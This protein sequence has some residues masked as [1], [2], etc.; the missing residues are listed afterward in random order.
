MADI[1]IFGDD[2]VVPE[3][4]KEAE[5][6]EIVE[7]PETEEKKNE[8]ESEKEDENKEMEHENGTEDKMVEDGG[9]IGEFYLLQNES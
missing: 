9:V 1:D 8:V 7:K 3:E 4:K 5:E 6:N 2:P